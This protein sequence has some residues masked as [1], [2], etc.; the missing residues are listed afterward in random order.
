MTTTDPVAEI[1]K[2]AKKYEKAQAVRDEAMAVLVRAMRAADKAG[3][4][5][6]EIQ[7]ASGLA[8]VTVYRAVDAP[9]PDL[10]VIK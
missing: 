10:R 9:E 1:K 8:R 2:A 3:V 5:R 6:N 7:R 4:A